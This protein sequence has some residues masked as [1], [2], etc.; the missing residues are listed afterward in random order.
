M[1]SSHAGNPPES[2]GSLEFGLCQQRGQSSSHPARGP[3]T[4]EDSSERRNMGRHMTSRRART[5]QLALR[6]QV[7]A[8]ERQGML[9]SSRR[10]PK[11]PACSGQ[12]H[13]LSENTAHLS[14]C[15]GRDVMCLVVDVGR[16]REL[17]GEPGARV[18]P[19]SGPIA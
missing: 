7:S 13:V 9:G 11:V 8:R 12:E 17:N 5:S 10:A 1:C 6:K 3:G 2:E 4:N 15:P 14:L 16:T 18:L 19:L